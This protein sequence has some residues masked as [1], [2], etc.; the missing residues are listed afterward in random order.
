MYLPYALPFLHLRSLQMSTKWW[1]RKTN[2]RALIIVISLILLDVGH[3]LKGVCLRIRVN[4]E[5]MSQ[6]RHQRSKSPLVNNL[7]L[8]N[9]LNKGDNPL[10]IIAHS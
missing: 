3:V 1:E 10:G 6:A 4:K 2:K 8:L 5:K 9:S 7:R